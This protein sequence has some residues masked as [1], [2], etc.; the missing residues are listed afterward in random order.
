MTDDAIKAAAGLL[1]MGIERGRADCFYCGEPGCT[2]GVQRFDRM[3]RALEEIAAWRI[4]DEVSP[5]ETFRDI[6]EMAQEAL[7]GEGKL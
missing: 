2:C 4:H 6:T 5:R 1:A 7:T 3:T